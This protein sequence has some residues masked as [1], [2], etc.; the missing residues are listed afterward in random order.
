M[1]G[2]TPNSGDRDTFPKLL[3]E[4]VRVRG[5][6]PA[7]REKDYGIWLTWTWSEIADEIQA[8][9]CGLKSLG[10]ERN[11][12]VTICG[13]NRP[14][15]YWAFTAIQCPSSRNWNKEWADLKEHQVHLVGLY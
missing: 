4:N 7:N 10:V 13:D 14:H 5:N 8:L 3:L 15:L 9:A 12:K 11:D 6:K 2:S 1:T